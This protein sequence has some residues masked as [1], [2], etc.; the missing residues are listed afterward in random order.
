MSDQPESQRTMSPQEEASWAKKAII[1]GAIATLLLAFPA[2]LSV[3]GWISARQE[4]SESARPIYAI[5]ALLNVVLFVIA[6]IC[7]SKGAELWKKR[8][9]K[10]TRKFFIIPLFLILASLGI[11]LVLQMLLGG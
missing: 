8:D 9:Y 7:C 3:I 10:G 5:A 4:L 6:G 11:T 2:V 1:G